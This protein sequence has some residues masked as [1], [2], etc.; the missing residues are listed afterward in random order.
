MWKEPFYRLRLCV[1]NP[2]LVKSLVQA[3]VGHNCSDNGIGQQ[4]T[5][6]FHVA[7]IDIQNVVTSDDIAFLI[8]TQ[9]TIRI[10]VVSKSNIQTFFYN[11]LL[12]TL[13]MS[14][15]CIVIDVQSVGLVIDH[16]GICA[17]CV[18]HRLRNIPRA[19]VG[20]VKT[21]L[22][23][24][25]GIDT[26][27][28]QIAHIAVAACY[29]V[30]RA[31]NM[32]SMC[33]RQ[34]WP[35]LVEHMELTINVV[36]NQQQRF[37]WHLLTVA[38]DQLDAIVIVWIM[39]GGNHNAA[40]KVIHTGNISHRRRGGNME[41]IGICTRCSQACHKAVLKHIRTTASILTNNNTSGL[42]I[43]VTLTESIIVPAKKT[44]YL[45][46]MVSC[47]SNSGF[48]TE[49][50]CSKVFSNYLFSPLIAKT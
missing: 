28:N 45:V 9:A 26:Q 15:A 21:D 13:N 44:P 1:T 43:S 18:K 2:L 31:A 34:L 6:L 32:L 10:A 19:A 27:R 30:H 39:A 50:V 42:V 24:L 38:V 47:Q 23:A 3:K 48:T 41:Q 35:V 7:T 8:Y 20:T 49:A 12:Q 14:R 11:K 36:L 46:G 25:E 17:E 37:F 29:I 22:D 40:V 4:L 16:I 5:T 33:K